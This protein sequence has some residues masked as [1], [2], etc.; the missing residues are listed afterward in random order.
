MRGMD[1]T[2]EIRRLH[3]TMYEQSLIFL[4]LK[5]SPDCDTSLMVETRELIMRIYGRIQELV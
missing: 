3:Q 5:G 1:K 4:S 2:Q